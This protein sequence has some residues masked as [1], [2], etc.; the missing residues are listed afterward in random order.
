MNREKAKALLPIITA[1]AEGKE[2]QFLN[3]KNE[4]EVGNDLGFTYKADRY[5]IKPEP[6]KVC[7]N[8]HRRSGGSLYTISWSDADQAKDAA[9]SASNCVGTYPVEIEL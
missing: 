4:W 1:Y 6:L 3:A 2:V 9:V 7:I 5:R 8:V